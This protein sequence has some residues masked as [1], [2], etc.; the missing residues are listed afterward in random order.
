MIHT[1]TTKVRGY[2]IDVYG[3]VNHARYLEFLEEARWSLTE[4]MNAMEVMQAEELGQ[5]V[6]NIN[7]TYRQPAVFGDELRIESKLTR[8]RSREGTI[9]QEIWRDDQLVVRADVRFM[10]IHKVT[11]QAVRIN[12]K[13]HQLLSSILVADR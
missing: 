13:L 9:R 4:T 5:I 12:G 3:H 2:H 7:I 11:G 6:T 8:L 10:L 1:T